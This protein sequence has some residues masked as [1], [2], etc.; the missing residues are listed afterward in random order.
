M[1]V[2]LRRRGAALVATQQVVATIRSYAAPT[3]QLL[4]APQDHASEG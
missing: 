3:L 4:L 2:F 1:A